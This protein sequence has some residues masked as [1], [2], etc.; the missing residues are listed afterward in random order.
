MNIYSYN[1]EKCALIFYLQDKKCTQ[2]V[3]ITVGLIYS[4]VSPF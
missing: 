1:M 2:M 3:M 4:L